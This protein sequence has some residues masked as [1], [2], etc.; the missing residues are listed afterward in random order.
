MEKVVMIWNRSVAQN[1]F[2]FPGRKKKGWSRLRDFA[3]PS[4]AVLAFLILAA[5]AHGELLHTISHY[6]SSQPFA[7]IQSTKMRVIQVQKLGARTRGI[8][9]QAVGI[10]VVQCTLTS[11]GEKHDGTNKDDPKLDEFA[12]LER[13][14]AKAKHVPLFDLRISFIDY[15]KKHN[16]DNHPS[17]ILTHDGNRFNQQGH[18]FVAG[19]MLRKFR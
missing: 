8:K 15:W 3:N 7:A 17:G 5:S 18:N 12:Q 2:A 14:V 4:T 10:Q 9:L 16:L 6:F 19:Q 1:C 13:E 11:V